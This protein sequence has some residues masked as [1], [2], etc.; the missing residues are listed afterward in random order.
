[1]LYVIVL[2]IQPA[3]TP[4][5]TPCDAPTL[6]NHWAT[7]RNDAAWKSDGVRSENE[8]RRDKERATGTEIEMGGVMAE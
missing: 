8:E 3:A 7:K 1:M 6:E 2:Y 4:I 5:A